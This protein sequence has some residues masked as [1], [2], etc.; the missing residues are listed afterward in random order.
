MAGYI[1]AHKFVSV[2]LLC[3]EWVSFQGGGLRVRDGENC[4]FWCPCPVKH[5][6]RE[7]P[8]ETLM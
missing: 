3:W 2:L 6:S 1:A 7:G 8:W 4:V 5:H